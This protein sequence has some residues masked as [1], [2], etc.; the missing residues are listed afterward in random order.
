[1]TAQL[2]QTNGD[3][4]N[5]TKVV[6]IEGSKRDF[7]GIK[8]T[9]RGLGMCIFYGLDTAQL[10][11]YVA[12][13]G[14]Q[15]S[16]KTEFFKW[17]KK[18]QGKDARKLAGYTKYMRP[19]TVGHKDRKVTLVKDSINGVPVFTVAQLMAMSH[20]QLNGV[21][22]T[23]G[24]SLEKVHDDRLYAYMSTVNGIMGDEPLENI[25]AANE[26]PEEVVENDEEVIYLMTSEE[27][28]SL[29][30]ISQ[31]KG[32]ARYLG[33]DLKGLRKRADIINHLVLAIQ[34]HEAQV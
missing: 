9:F 21:I 33:V 11:W 13:K 6:K 25:D 4:F 32:Y 34:E 10:F 24:R 27:L 30:N 18:Y 5:I 2:V 31:L 8:F 22:K 3:V 26:L 7:R 16:N 23:I 14:T 17:L 1:M 12:G 29:D 15:K 28:H 19:T 20:I